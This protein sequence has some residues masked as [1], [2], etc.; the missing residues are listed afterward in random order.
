ME[1]E[2]KTILDG[3]Q[4]S[5][6]TLVKRHESIETKTRELQTQTD[7]IDLKIAAGPHFVGGGFETKGLAEEIFENAE[8]KHM[9]EMGGRGR[10][11]IKIEDFGKKTLTN[12]AAGFATSG[13]LAIDR[14][15]GIVG[16]QFRQLR[17]RDL[18]RSQPTDLPQVDYVKVS[19][20][21]NEASPQVEASN[22]AQSDLT[23]ASVSER[24]RTI[25]HWV[26]CSK[27]IF[28]DLPGLSE[29][30]NGHLLYGLKLKEEAELLAGD[31][32]GE[33]LHGLIS[34]ATPFNVALLPTSYNRLDRIA[35]AIMQ[36][37]MSDFAVDI[38][39]LNTQD[40]WSMAL[41]KDSQGR[42]L[43]GDPSQAN[44]PRLWGRPIAVTNSMSSGSFLVGSSAT[45]LIR[46]RQEAIVEISDSHSD[47]FIKNMLA[48]RCEERLALQVMRPAAWIYSNSMST[49]PAS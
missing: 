24:V 48:I 41:T 21:D 36:A 27:Q 32:T 33:H 25:A 15:P 46:D 47:F 13:V 8:F 9:G 43:F 4:T 44:I 39:V 37:E 16:V 49:S 3:V 20:F 10:V 18:L 7:A 17:I 45:A 29:T 26:P 11:T 23:L 28:M 1:I 31:G 42:Y 35:T 40:F 19:A 30:I 34:Q 6:E 12:A 14:L 5:V 22:K 2:L 38:I